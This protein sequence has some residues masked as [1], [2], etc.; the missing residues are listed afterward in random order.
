MGKTA[1][2]RLLG[3][4]S[5]RQRLLLATLSSTPILIEDIRADETWPGLRNHEISLLRLFETVCDDCHVEIN[6]TGIFFNFIFL[7]IFQSGLVAV[8][9]LPPPSEDCL[10][11]LF[12]LNRYQIKVQTWNYYRWQATPCARLWPLALHWLFSGATYC[13]VFVCKTAPHH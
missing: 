3:S 2:K 4:Q 12:G 1:Y 5:F 11:I 8:T 6:E 9:Q 13:V 10:F 7:F